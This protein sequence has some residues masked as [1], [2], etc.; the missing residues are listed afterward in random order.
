[1]TDADFNEYWYPD[2]VAAFPS[3]TKW[4]GNLDD[5]GRTV[6]KWQASF[7]STTLTDAMTAT[8]KLLEEGLGQY[9][10]FDDVP[11][12]IRELAAAAANARRFAERGTTM[13]PNSDGYKCDDCKDSGWIDIWAQQDI[14]YCR[15]HGNLPR[16][17]MNQSV[18]VAC[19]RCEDGERRYRKKDKEKGIRGM[20]RFDGRIHCLYET[21]DPSKCK[22][23]DQIVQ[24]VAF[25]GTVQDWVPVESYEDVTGSN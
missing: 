18:S 21:V 19:H 4:L 6:A 13:K 16:A 1:M 3:V 9:G 17:R 7:R 20:P 8:T 11:S 22:T 15:K 24:F 23:E 2:F 25:C 12:R 5:A 10:R 14:D